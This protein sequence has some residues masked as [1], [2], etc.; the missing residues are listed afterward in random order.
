MPHVRR[1]ARL[2]DRDGLHARPC[3]RVAEVARKASAAITITHGDAQAD[4]TSVLELMM[5]TAAC[6]DELSVDAEGSD[7]EDAVA[8]IVA[9]LEAPGEA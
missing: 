6:G 3:A 2:A 4:A 5:L 7:A 9:V 1:T 8:R